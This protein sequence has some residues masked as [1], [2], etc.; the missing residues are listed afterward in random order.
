MAVNSDRPAWW[1]RF[2][3]QRWRRQPAPLDCTGP[4]SQFAA[5]AVNRRLAD[6]AWT[7]NSL[8][9][10][11]ARWTGRPDTVNPAPLLTARLMTRGANARRYPT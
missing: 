6:T 10:V 11:P 2:V 9:R 5:P 1:M 3:P 8:G 7:G 4:A